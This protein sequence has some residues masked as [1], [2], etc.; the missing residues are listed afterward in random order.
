MTPSTS[1]T[2]NATDK[3][4]N[5]CNYKCNS[6]STWNGSACIAN[7]ATLTVMPESIT[8]TQNQGTTKSVTASAGTSYTVTFNAN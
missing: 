1:K 8:Y 5:A 3:T 2:Y 4:V 6:T 7:T